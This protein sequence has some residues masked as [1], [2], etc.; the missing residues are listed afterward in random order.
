[1]GI[2]VVHAVFFQRLGRHRVDIWQCNAVVALLVRKD[3]DS[4]QLGTDYWTSYGT[5]PNSDLASENDSNILR[6]NTYMG[7]TFEVQASS[8]RVA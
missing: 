8:E 4:M 2:S 3:D 7:D 6:R 1:M 5:A